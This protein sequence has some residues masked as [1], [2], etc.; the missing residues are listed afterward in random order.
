LIIDV[1]PK[2]KWLQTSPA[3][4]NTCQKAIEQPVLQ[5]APECRNRQQCLQCG[6]YVHSAIAEQNVA[7]I[8]FD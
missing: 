5:Q 6:S 8:L 1:T 3:E 4:A 2:V 7:E